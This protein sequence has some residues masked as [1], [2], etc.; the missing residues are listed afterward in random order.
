MII[1]VYLVVHRNCI[2]VSSENFLKK[3]KRKRKIIRRCRFC[4]NL[5]LHTQKILNQTNKHVLQGVLQVSIRS[6]QCF[7]NT[8][9]SFKYVPLSS[10]PFITVQSVTAERNYPTEPKTKHKLLSA[11]P[12]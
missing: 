2:V 12:T 10:V 3:K 11:S 6:N 1:G 8:Q 5:P 4:K 9:V 7:F